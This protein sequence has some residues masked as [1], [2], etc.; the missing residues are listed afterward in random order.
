V[1]N[2]KSVTTAHIT[3]YLKKLEIATSTKNPHLRV[4]GA[5]FRFLK[6]TGYIEQNPVAP[7]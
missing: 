2:I 7:L 1:S 3:L 4:I 6:N 5:F